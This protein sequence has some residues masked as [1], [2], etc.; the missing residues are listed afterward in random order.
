MLKINRDL[1]FDP[2]ICS[3]LY[4]YTSMDE[5]LTIISNVNEKDDYFDLRHYLDSSE[6]DNTIFIIMDY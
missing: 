2:S 1:N 3:I 6:L 5:Y 4:T